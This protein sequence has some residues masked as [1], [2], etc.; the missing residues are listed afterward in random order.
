M[1]FVSLTASQDY[2][3]K[4]WSAESYKSEKVLTIYKVETRGLP[5]RVYFLRFQTASSFSLLLSLLFLTLYVAILVLR[6][7]SVAVA[8]VSVPSDSAPRGT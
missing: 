2:F 6:I 5:R 1:I 7:I 8:R 3:A 4:V